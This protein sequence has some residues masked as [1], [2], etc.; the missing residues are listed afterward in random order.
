VALVIGSEVHKQPGRV[1][2]TPFTG[3]KLNTRLPYCSWLWLS[4]AALWRTEL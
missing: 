4:S 1:A 3:L 2:A